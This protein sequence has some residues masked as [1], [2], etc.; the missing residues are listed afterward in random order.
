MPLI[1]TGAMPGMTQEWLQNLE[2]EMQRSVRSPLSHYDRRGRKLVL[3]LGSSPGFRAAAEE[4][5]R[6]AYDL[7]FQNKGREG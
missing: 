5:R 7:H 3:T 6:A 1:K 4:V 2:A